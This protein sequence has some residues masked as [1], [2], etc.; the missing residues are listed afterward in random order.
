MA[1]IKAIL[2]LESKQCPDSAWGMFGRIDTE[3]HTQE[4]LQFLTCEK[5]N[6]PT[7]SHQTLATKF[8]YDFKVKRAPMCNLE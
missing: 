5:F 7:K 8:E 1:P 6:L 2:S 3:W 4:H